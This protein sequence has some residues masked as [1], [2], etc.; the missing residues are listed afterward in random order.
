MVFSS[1]ALRYYAACTRF[2]DFMKNV[3]LYHAQFIK[4]GYPAH[5]LH[6]ALINVFRRHENAKH[7]S[8]S[9]PTEWV[10]ELGKSTTRYKRQKRKNNAKRLDNNTSTHKKPRQPPA[11]EQTHPRSMP[12]R[13]RPQPQPQ[14]QSLKRQHPAG[15]GL[16]HTVWL[17]GWHVEQ[18][19]TSSLD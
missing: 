19:Q 7:G 9:T 5:L 13:K 2:C 11:K 12:H 10:K 18:Q 3:K 1:E 16:N 15:R 8:Q 4:K 17:L 14:S 6:M